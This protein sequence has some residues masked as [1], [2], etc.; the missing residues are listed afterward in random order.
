VIATPDVK[1][2]PLVTGIAGEKGFL[3][4]ACDGVWNTLA[5]SDVGSV[6]G[7]VLVEVKKEDPP[8]GFEQILNMMADRIVRKAYDAGSA[9]NLTAVVVGIKEL[10]TSNHLKE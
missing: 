6:V 10:A 1:H 4:L 3:V 7:A 2:F 9:D 8:C 5:Q